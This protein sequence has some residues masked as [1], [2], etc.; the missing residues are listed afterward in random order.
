[1][2]NAEHEEEPQTGDCTTEQPRAA[3]KQCLHSLSDSAA[4]YWLTLFM[5]AKDHAVM[6][7]FHFSLGS[8]EAIELITH[9]LF[10]LI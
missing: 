3:S 7:C 6:N 10:R 9:L 4:S 1:M 2:L 8:V 5:C